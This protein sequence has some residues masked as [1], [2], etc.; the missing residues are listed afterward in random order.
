MTFEYLQCENLY[1]NVMSVD[2]L[3]TKVNLTLNIYEHHE[4]TCLCHMQTTKAQI[5]LCTWAV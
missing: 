4:K 3:D 5:R 1:E 2:L